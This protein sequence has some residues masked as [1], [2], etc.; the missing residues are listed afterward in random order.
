MDLRRI[1]SAMHH[2]SWFVALNAGQMFEAIGPDLTAQELLK[3]VLMQGSDRTLWM[4]GSI[5]EK[6]WGCQAFE[7]LCER[8][9]MELAPG[10]GYLYE[11]MM[12]AA[13]GPKQLERGIEIA[14]SG[15]ADES[16]EIA[17]GAAEALRTVDVRILALYRERLRERLD[18]WQERGLWCP[19][20]RCVLAGRACDVC[21]TV[22]REPRHHLIYLL[23]TVKGLSGEE[24]LALAGDGESRVRDE[25]R[26]ALIQLALD[27]SGVMRNVM[28][29]I[30]SG[31]DSTRL[32]NEMLKQPSEVLKPIAD[33]LLQLLQS[34][35]AV[36]REVIVRALNSGWISKE[37]AADL[38][39]R[40][41]E[42][43]SPRVR[44]AA[45][46][47]IREQSET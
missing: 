29:Q 13:Q 21:H 26:R 31:F 40:A 23:S 7:I 33:Q 47:V 8:L 19:S 32:L 39:R 34:P 24:L 38:G 4:I 5:A 43:D 9:Q 27:D 18:Q 10:C 6:V 36:I 46:R 25:A 44:T 37:M 2:P 42:D 15:L 11:A 30:E 20:C 12:K 28:A 17:E 22:P 14:I 3:S 16:A 45:T 41:L 1:A 35:H